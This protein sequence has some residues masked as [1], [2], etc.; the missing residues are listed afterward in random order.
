MI[1][2]IVKVEDP[3]RGITALRAAIMNIAGTGKPLL[4]VIRSLEGA[5][6]AMIQNAG[7][8]RRAAVAIA[9]MALNIDVLNFELELMGNVAVKS[10][11]AFNKVAQTM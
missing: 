11:G 9:I 8:A 6:L 10:M 2:T 1:A 4:E 5:N 7:F 3:A